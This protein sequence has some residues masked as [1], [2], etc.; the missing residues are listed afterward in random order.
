MNKKYLSIFLLLGAVGI[1]GS[2]VFFVFGVPNSKPAQADDEGQTISVSVTSTL[3]FSVATSTLALGTL[4]PGAP[5]TVETSATASTNAS[6]G[7]TLS[8]KRDDAD[9]TLDLSTDA[10][11]NFPDYTAWDSGTPNSNTAPGATL[12][13]RVMTT[14]TDAGLYNSTW[15]GSDDT[16]NAKYAGIPPTSQSIAT[17]G[18]YV[19]TSQTVA[20]KFRADA[21]A[22]QKTG[23][24]D[25]AITLT[26]L[27]AI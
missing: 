10:A 1:V 18:S 7:W 12:S 16:T 24:Y 21:P 20:Y 6:N 3:T 5:V 4:T 15:W 19:A 9:T 17:I 25:G 23:S 11:T 27:V 2:L 22:T 26:A 8:I 14:G 13:F